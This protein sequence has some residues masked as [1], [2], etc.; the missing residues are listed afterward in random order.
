MKDLV[1]NLVDGIL[2]EDEEDALQPQ[3]MTSQAAAQV[4]N[5]VLLPILRLL[6]HDTF[7]LA[8]QVCKEWHSAIK[9]DDDLWKHHAMKRFPPIHI[10]M[11][12]FGRSGADATWEATYKRLASSQTSCYDCAAYTSR[13]TCGGWKQRALCHGCSEGYVESR[14]GQR[15]M[16]KTNARFVYRLRE[17]DLQA[18]PKLVDKNPIHDKF[19][20]M[21]LYRK[22]DLRRAAI[23]RWD[24]IGEMLKHFR[25]LPHVY[26]M[27]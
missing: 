25:P 9:G 4:P 10:Y 11:W 23:Q 27:Q 19:E 13:T 20:L 8:M 24:G 1:R 21:E 22:Q 18:L 16:T 17:E 14:P 26:N 7:I 15:L 6:D 12:R 2:H 5:E 3:A